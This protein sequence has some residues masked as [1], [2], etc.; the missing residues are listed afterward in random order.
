V[1]SHGDDRVVTCLICLVF[2]FEWK[3]GLGG[4]AGGRTLPDPTCGADWWDY[5]LG[6]GKKD[7]VLV[8]LLLRDC[9]CFDVAVLIV[10]I[11]AIYPLMCHLAHIQQLFSF[12]LGLSFVFLPLKR[13]AIFFPFFQLEGLHQ[14]F[15]HDE[16]PLC[17]AIFLSLAF[18]AFLLGII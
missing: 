10:A 9:T 2:Y 3:G 13:S 18:L 8:L 5:K 1:S 15:I 7:E 16:F 4:F 17:I 6:L 11:K 14:V 12:L